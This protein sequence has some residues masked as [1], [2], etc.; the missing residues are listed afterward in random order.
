MVLF[1]VVMNNPNGPAA[2]TLSLIPFFGPT[3][4]MLRIAVA[5]PLLWQILLSIL[6]IIGAILLVVWVAAKI[7]RVG[8]LMY[9]KRPS[10]AELGRWLRYS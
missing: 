8:V 4:M 10:L 6:L 9:G 5:T 3:L 7:Y 2:V 1:G